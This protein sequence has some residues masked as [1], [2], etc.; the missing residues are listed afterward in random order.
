MT[1]TNH[2]PPKT[3]Q[4]YEKVWPNKTI[5]DYL[6]QCVENSP[7]KEAIIDG[8]SRYTYSEL[9]KKVERVALGLYHYGLRKG[10]VISV[11]LPNW[12]EF[13][14]VHYAATMLGAITNPLIPIYR[15][16]EIGYMV[17]TA[18]SKMIVIPDHFRGFCY[19]D[20][21]ERLRGD[22]PELDHV[23]V[24]GDEVPGEMKAFTELSEFNWEDTLNHH[25]LET[26][27]E[28]N[29]VTEIIFTSGTTGLPK[30]VMHTHNTLCMSTNYWIE[31]LRLTDEDV[32][33]MPSTFGHQTGFGYGVRLPTTIGGTAVYQDIWNPEQ[34]LQ[35]VEKER[36]SFTASATPFLQ[37]VVQFE[38]VKSFNLKT[39]RAFVSLGAPIPRPLVKEAKENVPFTILSGW[40][41]TENGLVTLTK[42]DD[43]TEKLTE[44]DGCPF[45]EMMIKTVD[46]N[47]NECE[48]NEEAPYS[49]G[50]HFSSA[51]FISQNRHLNLRDNWFITGD[52]ATIDVDGYVRITGRDKDIIIRGGENIPV[53]YIENVLYEHPDIKGAQ[54]VAVPDERLQE[55]ACAIVELVPKASH[56]T[57]SELQSYLKD[58]GVA[59]QYWPEYLEVIDEF[60]R[61]PSGKVQKYKLRDMLK[62]KA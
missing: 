18:S 8:R 23:F 34:F 39:L 47:G 51:T 16:R 22:W 50:L 48:A 7:N 25:S 57:L 17:K 26:T 4:K 58:K 14:I 60:P 15:D 21:I 12:N 27:H 46:E 28:P 9:S 44:T 62:T 53:A 40:G 54:V 24:I 36:I 43:S 31:R 19:T 2:V 13:V 41:Q 30:G 55:K 29:D 38:N 33:F 20:M 10:D 42:L 56:L 59:K 6:K 49:K 35:S 1:E 61:T 45:P 37:D 32:M 11:Q 5:L 3:L 52:R